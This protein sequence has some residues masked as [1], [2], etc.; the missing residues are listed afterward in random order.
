MTEKCPTQDFACVHQLIAR[1][2]AIADQ[3]A[4]LVEVVDGHLAVVG[5]AQMLVHYRALVRLLEKAI[6]GY[7]DDHG[8]PPL[9]ADLEGVRW[10]TT[11]LLS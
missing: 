7:T 3:A 2:Q 1:V 10:L 5:A 4:G 6:E 11:E 9:M 8:Q